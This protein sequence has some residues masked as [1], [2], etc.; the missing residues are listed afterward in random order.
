ML[1]P[2]KHRQLAAVRHVT[3]HKAERRLVAVEKK[4]RAGELR[5]A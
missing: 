3:R 4:I 1:A 2:E 5:K